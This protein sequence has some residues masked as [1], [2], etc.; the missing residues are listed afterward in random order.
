M[1]MHSCSHTIRQDDLGQ[2]PH[3][4]KLQRKEI[5]KEKREGGRG[6]E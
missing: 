6:E 3:L 1:I 2:Y 4:V 5:K